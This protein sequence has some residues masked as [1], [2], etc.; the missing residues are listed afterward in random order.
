MRPLDSNFPEVAVGGW[1]QGT[2]E[3][4]VPAV[5][6]GSV[7]TMPRSGGVT[8]TTSVGALESVEVAAAALDP[9]DEDGAGG[10]GEVPAA[11]DPVPG[12]AGDAAATVVGEAAGRGDD[13]VVT[14]RDTALPLGAV[15]VRPAGREPSPPARAGA[16]SGAP[17]SPIT[18]GEPSGPRA[19]DTGVVRPAVEEPALFP[20]TTGTV[21]RSAVTPTA[22]SAPSRSRVGRI[23]S[24]ARIRSRRRTLVTDRR[25]VHGGVAD[26]WC[27]GNPP[28][29]RQSRF[30]TDEETIGVSI[31]TVGEC[32]ARAHVGSGVGPKPGCR[33]LP[34]PPV[35]PD[36]SHRAPWGIVRPVRPPR[37]ARRR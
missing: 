31:V 9:P 18:T 6:A 13:A 32:G 36:G 10:A 3:L 25:S 19:A 20:D 2:D 1:G 12:G 8:G 15:V 23:R 21:R 4:E 28:G 35:P 33:A 24:R 11:T 16:G 5:G 27:T 29:S 30:V 22:T 34:H 14:A 17:S 7:G 26:R 37:G